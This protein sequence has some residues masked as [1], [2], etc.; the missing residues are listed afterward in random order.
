M[1]AEHIA[2]RQGPAMSCDDS[3]GNRTPTALTGQRMDAL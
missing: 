1:V 3:L 2:A